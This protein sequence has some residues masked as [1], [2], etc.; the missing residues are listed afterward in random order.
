MLARTT[1]SQSGAFSHALHNNQASVLLK[2]R[3]YSSD[4][5]FKL[6]DS[7]F[8]NNTRP[9]SKDRSSAKPTNFKPRRTQNAFE[10]PDEKLKIKSY[11]PVTGEIENDGLTRYEQDFF[12]TLEWVKILAL[13]VQNDE[14]PKSP[15]VYNPEGCLVIQKTR[16]VTYDFSR[17]P[18]P[19][20]EVF[21]LDMNKLP[22]EI[23]PI[24][25]HYLLLICKDRFDAYTNTVTFL[26]SDEIKKTWKEVLEFKQDKMAEDVAKIPLDLSNIKKTVG[27]K[28]KDLS[29]PKEWLEN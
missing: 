12:E 14:L 20:E 18:V 29:F 10:N 17:V 11:R 28:K 15:G 24:Q 2:L 16:E 26:S 4:S 25:R 3:P 23:T 13:K 1:K 21:I 7:A 5:T 22:A 9:L 6:N 8:R 19:D 27:R